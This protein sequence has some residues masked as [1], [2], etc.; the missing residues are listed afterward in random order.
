MNYGSGPRVSSYLPALRFRSLTRFYDPLMA[1][2]TRESVFRPMLVDAAAPAPGERV[3]DLGCG[4]G[5]V[6]LLVAAREPAAQVVGVDPD[7]EILALAR[8]KAEAQGATVTFEEALA[9]ELPVASGSVDVVVSSLVFHH[10][11]PQAKRDV[12]AECLRVLR[13]GGRLAIADWGAPEGP[14]MWLASRSVRLLDGAATTRESLA[15][16][17]PD[18]L[19]AAGFED[20]REHGAVRTAFGRLVIHRA[21]RPG[22]RQGAESSSAEI[23]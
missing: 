17:L 8:R 3:L 4:T 5:A 21:T 15:G 23:T 6:A 9:Q 19:S 10:L 1:L 18:V 2:G 12:A 11:L 7:P 16:G 22:P 13:P 14:G 20:L